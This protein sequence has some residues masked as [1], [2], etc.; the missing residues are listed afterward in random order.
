[1]AAAKDSATLERP[2]S[3]HGHQVSVPRIQLPADVPSKADGD[4]PPA[5]SRMDV[6]ASIWHVRTLN[7]QVEDFISASCPALPLE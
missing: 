7:Q 4:G 3:C 1:M 5:E 6:L 2:V